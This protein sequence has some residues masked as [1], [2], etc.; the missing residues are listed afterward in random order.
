MDGRTG[1]RYKVVESGK[2]TFSESKKIC[3]ALGGYLP[4]PRDELENNFLDSLNSESFYL[5]MTDSA[6]EGDW[7][8]ESDSTEVT[9]KNWV[10]WTSIF[11]RDPPNGGTSENCALVLKHNNNKKL[12]HSTKAWIDHECDDPVHTFTV[13]CE[14]G[15]NI[16]YLI[17]YI[18]T[19]NRFTIFLSTT[20]C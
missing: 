12:G 4:E 9:W 19:V 6:V 2:K 16:F 18:L 10:D 8:W 20:I 3:T 1:K 7:L 17:Y 11:T 15:E 5:G 13:V 14:K